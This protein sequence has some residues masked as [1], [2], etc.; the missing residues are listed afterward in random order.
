MELKALFR[1]LLSRIE[2]VELA[3]DPAWIKSNINVELKRLPIRYAMRR[4]AA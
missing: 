1:E 2:S 4:Q 3:A